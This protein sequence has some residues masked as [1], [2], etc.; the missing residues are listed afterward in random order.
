MKKPAAD[1][2]EPT[3]NKSDYFYD[4]D[5]DADLIEVSVATQYGVRLRQ[6]ADTITAAEWSR[7]VSGLMAETPLGRVVSIRMEKDRKIIS[8]YGY[9]E[10]KIKRDWEMFKF[11]RM[12]AGQKDDSIRE[13]QNMLKSMF[14][15][16]EE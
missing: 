4:T 13:L 8:K 3:S 16:R 7:L 5:F 11:G 15:K 9:T 2:A 12:S 14:G 6:E 10:R 1:F